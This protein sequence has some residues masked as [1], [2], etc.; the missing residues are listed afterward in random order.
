MEEFGDDVCFQDVAGLASVGGL[1]KSVRS[2]DRIVGIFVGEEGQAPAEGCQAGVFALFPVGVASTVW[3]R[4][5]RG[6]GL[7]QCDGSGCLC[8]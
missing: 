2:D 8:Q 4:N 6:L 7:G 3:L 5:R 1:V